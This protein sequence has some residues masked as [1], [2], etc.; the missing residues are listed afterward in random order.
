MLK[1]WTITSME[2]ILKYD[3]IKW[4][5][6]RWGISKV[7]CRNIEVNWFII[8]HTRMFVFHSKVFGK[9]EDGFK[10]VKQGT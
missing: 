3:C 8:S 6:F 2:T 1:A 10:H 4:K 9:L 7:N 5:N